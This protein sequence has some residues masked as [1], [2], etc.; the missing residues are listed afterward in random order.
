MR[1]SRVARRTII[2]LAVP[3]LGLQVAKPS[4]DALSAESSSAANPVAA[5]FPNS[6]VVNLA[7]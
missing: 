1:S 3:A 5:E 2:A 6:F 7:Q 4:S